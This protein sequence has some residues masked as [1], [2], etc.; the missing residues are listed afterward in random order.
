[1]SFRRFID[2]LKTDGNLI[3]IQEPVSP[4]YDAAR[5]AG[6]EKPHLFH[7]INGCRVAANLLSS[8][9]A[10][11]TALGI[12]R[13]DMAAHLA[14]AEPDGEIKLVADSP[15]TEIRSKPDLL[16]LPV[17]TYFK[18]GL[19]GKI[20]SQHDLLRRDTPTSCTKRHWSAERSSLSQ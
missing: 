8:R 13:E 20:N 6:N 3:E 1:M 15:T 9:V 12:N 4:E 19:S 11:C 2:Q 7:S 16:K 10:L 5:I 14:S 18:N 17:L